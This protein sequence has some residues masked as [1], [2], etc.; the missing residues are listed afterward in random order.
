ML[1]EKGYLVNDIAEFLNIAE[2]CNPKGLAWLRYRRRLAG[3]R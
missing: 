1:V 3:Y 2:N